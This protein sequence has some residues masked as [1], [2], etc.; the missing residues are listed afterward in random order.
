MNS[1]QLLTHFERIS[2]APDAIFRLRQFIL[3]LAIRGRL[4]EHDSG[5]EPVSELLKPSVIV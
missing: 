1:A 5:D 2:D 4:V 3:E